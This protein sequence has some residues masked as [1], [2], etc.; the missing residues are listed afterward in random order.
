MKQALVAA[1][2]R[3]GPGSE[4]AAAAL[5]LGLRFCAAA[6]I[7]LVISRTARLGLRRT[8]SR[9]AWSAGAWLGFLLI[10]GFGLQMRGLADVTPAVSAFLTSL[11]VLFT[12]AMSA[13]R[14]RRGLRAS[15]AVGAILATIGA[16]LVR[17]RPELR[18]TTGEWLTVASAFVFAAHILATDRLTRVIAPMALTF[19]SFVVIALGNVVVFGA[20][21]VI[22]GPQWERVGE[23]LQAREFLVPL[24]LTTTLATV[25]ALSLM[26]LFQR[27]LDPVRAAILYAFEPIFAVIFGVFSGLDTL[28]PWLW[29]GGAL[30]LAGNLIAE[31]SSWRSVPEAT[32]V[33]A[34]S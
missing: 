4:T 33:R 5:F 34:D 22:D 31:L 32:P 11:Y 18:F 2:S 29:T 20:C 14:S 16:G 6:L 12:A 30:I 8:G 26:N 7:V 17:G 1:S 3:L 13:A 10:L 19:T 25:V 9:P 21:A 15:L 23:L 24:I 27:E 28:T